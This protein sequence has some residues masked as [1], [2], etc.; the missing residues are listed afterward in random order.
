M[1]CV[2]K[3]ALATGTFAEAT[4]SDAIGGARDGST[5]PNPLMNKFNVS[6]Q[7]HDTHGTDGTDSTDDSS[8]DD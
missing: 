4:R 6:D 8:D 5:R 3:E 1:W 7:M 2:N